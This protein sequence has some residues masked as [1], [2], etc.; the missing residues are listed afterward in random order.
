[1]NDIN[2]IQSRLYLIQI[3]EDHVEF[4]LFDKSYQT[5]SFLLSNIINW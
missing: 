4:K 1:M 3:Y 5:L 2:L